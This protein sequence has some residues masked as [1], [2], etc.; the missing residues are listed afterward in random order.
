M[1]VQVH[2][3]VETREGHRGPRSVSPLFPWDIS[4]CSWSYFSTR[5][6]IFPVSISI[7]PS[8]HHRQI[9]FLP[10][11]LLKNQCVLTHFGEDSEYLIAGNLFLWWILVYYFPV[12]NHIISTKASGMYIV[13]EN[14]STWKWV[15]DFLSEFSEN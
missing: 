14:D 6:N 3:S 8:W 5:P 7:L 4:Q 10:R 2:V 13:L 1:Y 12:I 15:G 11:L 9:V